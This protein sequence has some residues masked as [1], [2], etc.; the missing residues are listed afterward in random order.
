MISLEI[1]CLLLLVDTGA[2]TTAL[3]GIRYKSI[4]VNVHFLIG[5]F[6]QH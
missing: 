2:L 4:L 1:H 3:F 5:K 6:I